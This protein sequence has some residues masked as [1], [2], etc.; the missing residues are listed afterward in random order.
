MPGEIIPE[1]R[2][3]SV[4]I[5]KL[6]TMASDTA[7]PFLPVEGSKADR[8]A[9]FEVIGGSYLAVL[10]CHGIFLD[11]ENEVALLVANA[12]RLPPK[13]APASHRLSWRHIAEYPRAAQIIVSPACSSGAG[14]F[15]G[16]GE[17][18]GLFREFQRGGT[19]ALI[20]PRWR[21]HAPTAGELVVD[22][23]ARHLVDGKPLGV[24]TRDAALAA[25]ERGVPP[26]H[27]WN[28]A[29]EGD[30]R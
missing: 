17:R 24:A 10:L 25:I 2:A 15:A 22:L 21:S 4:G 7:T 18:L 5:G 11:R 6:G 8:D 26:R 27:A 30:W 23:V 20:A 13:S 16:L 19:R 9:M 3:T 12:G 1:S 14:F 28:L 29:L